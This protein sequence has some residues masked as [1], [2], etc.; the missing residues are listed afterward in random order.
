MQ[1]RGIK[2]VPIVHDGKVV[3]IV[4]R[5]NL[6]QGFAR[7][8]HA[9]GAVASDD[10]LR[11]R[12][13][14]ELDKHTR[15]FRRQQ[16]RGREWC[17]P[18]AGADLLADREGRCPGAIENARRKRVMNNIV[19]LPVEAAQLAARPADRVTTTIRASMSLKRIRLELARTPDFPQGSPSHGYEFLAPLDA[20]GH[21]EPSAWPHAKCTCTVR[22]F[23]NNEP[24]EHG[25]LI[26]RRNGS[27][28]FSRKRRRR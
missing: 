5:A 16:R 7:Q 11:D 19:V 22:R 1:S 24:D 20:G 2:R 21:L 9:V 4:S 8:P 23:W 27:W 15:G 28:A 3:G 26:H 10:N 12:V 13:N 17:G 6:L 18:S 25:T 14:E